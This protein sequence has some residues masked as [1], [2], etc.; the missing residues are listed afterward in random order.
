MAS[1]QIKTGS[2]HALSPSI[3]QPGDLGTGFLIGGSSQPPDPRGRKRGLE[4]LEEH[5]S[6]PELETPKLVPAFCFSDELW[7]PL[8]A[9]RPRAG[10]FP[11]LRPSHLSCLPSSRA[12]PPTLPTVCLLLTN[13]HIYVCSPIS[14]ETSAASKSVTR[15][16]GS[17]V[18]PRGLQFSGLLVLLCLSAPTTSH[19]ALGST[20]ISHKGT[21]RAGS[22]ALPQS[23][24]SGALQA[25]RRD[26]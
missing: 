10:T 5:N 17:T 20:S 9:T 23:L 4:P 2:I 3:L 1:S 14:A 6:S 24:H 21:I 16:W 8:L 25:G 19:T 12:S 7:P 13:A 11:G 15:L 18:P 26:W 22:P